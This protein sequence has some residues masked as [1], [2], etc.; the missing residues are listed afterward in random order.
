MKQ[1]DRICKDRTVSAAPKNILHC[2]S[3]QSY[4]L[5]GAML[6]LFSCKGSWLSLEIRQLLYRESAL[7]V[8]LAPNLD[9]QLNIFEP[10]L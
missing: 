10:A 7:E 5:T 8:D 3:H 1:I 2:Y 4:P 9:P 6:L